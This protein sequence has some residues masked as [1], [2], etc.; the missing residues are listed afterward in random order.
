M[1]CPRADDMR[2]D[3]PR[4]ATTQVVRLAWGDDNRIAAMDHHASAGWPTPTIAPALR[5]KDAK[6]NLY[7]PFSIQAPDHWHT[8]GAHLVRPLQ[9]H[10]AD[11]T[12]P[13]GFRRH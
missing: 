12:F 7:D 3:C 8:V 13:P 4:S 9:N 2:F 10:L 1:V 5:S 6:G 11:R